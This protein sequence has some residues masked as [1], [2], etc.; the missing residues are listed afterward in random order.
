MS[1]VETKTAA[2]IF[3]VSGENIRKFAEKG[4]VQSRE[5]FEKL[6]ASAKEAADSLDASAAVV[7][8]GLS[9]FNAK[10]FEALQANTYS[11]LDHFA[12]LAA[13]KDVNE[14]ISMQSAHAEQQVK[15]INDQAKDLSD[16]A[17]K[18]AKES[19]ESL[20]GQFEKIT[21]VA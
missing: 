14:A 3:E 1:N 7:A 2:E 18:I 10:A 20:K 17:Q 21:K 12:K 11:T 15:V 4:L 5:A 13:A 8:K 9:E 6:N 16:L 19:F